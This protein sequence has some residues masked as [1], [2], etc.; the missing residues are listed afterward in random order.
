[1]DPPIKEGFNDWKNAH[2]RLAAHERSE[3]HTTSIKNAH[4]NAKL[5]HAVLMLRLITN[6]KWN[7]DIGEKS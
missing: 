2:S 5:S 7:K 1:M 3:C 4:E 6:F